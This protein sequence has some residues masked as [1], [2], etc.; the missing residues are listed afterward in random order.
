MNPSSLEAD[1]PLQSLSQTTQHSSPPQ[2]ANRPKR[3]PIQLDAAGVGGLGSRPFLIVLLQRLVV[4]PAA[5]LAQPFQ[6]DP[7][8]QVDCAGDDQAS[9]A[10]PVGFNS[11]RGQ[12]TMSGCC[13]EH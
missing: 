1:H 8:H 12:F 3:A 2:V 5:A 9:L 6:H 11:W 4:E 13:Y 10:C 7:Q